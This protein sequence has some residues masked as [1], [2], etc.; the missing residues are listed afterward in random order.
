MSKV[1]SARTLIPLALLI[2]LAAL[3]YVDAADEPK[4]VTAKEVKQQVD[5]YD[6][7]RKA[8]ETSGVAKKFPAEMMDRADELMKKSKAAL[9]AGRVLEAYDLA[10]RARW[11]IPSAPAEL[12]DNVSRILGDPRLR[13][14]NWVMAVA[15]STDG[16]K[17][18]SA[19]EDG[20]LKIWDVATGKELRSIAES[21]SLRTLAFSPDGK[22]L[23]SAGLD[24][25]INQIGR[26][27]V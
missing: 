24:K 21:N 12:P 16:T 20:V 8:A 13:H 2:S 25:K 23:A 7:E 1:L 3:R 17:L 4:P 11:Q 14:S 10:R 6:A 26:A 18:A 9:D 15:Y 19:G 27:H 5:Q 22:L